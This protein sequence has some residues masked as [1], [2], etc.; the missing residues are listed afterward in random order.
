MDPIHRYDADS[1][2]DFVEAMDERRTLEIEKQIM[3]LTERLTDDYLKYQQ[4]TLSFTGSPWTVQ[5]AAQ[6]QAPSFSHWMPPTLP[7]AQTFGTVVVKLYPFFKQD[8]ARFMIEYM[9]RAQMGLDHVPDF[10]G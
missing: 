3:D 4:S 7:V 9:L 6:S 5:I 2:I 8:E 1:Q 10:G